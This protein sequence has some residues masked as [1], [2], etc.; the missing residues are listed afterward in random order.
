MKTYISNELNVW[1]ERIVSKSETTDEIEVSLIDIENQELISEF[2][3][4]LKDILDSHIVDEIPV[5]FISATFIK[6]EKN[7]SGYINARADSNH[8]SIKF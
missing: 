5:V 3:T 7:L 1:K 6:T 2:N 8:L 4:K